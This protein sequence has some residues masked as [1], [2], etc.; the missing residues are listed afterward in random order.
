[1]QLPAKLIQAGSNTLH[2]EIHKR[3]DYILNKEELPQQWKE[4]IIILIYKRGEKTAII[5]D[6]YHC[7]KLHTK[8]YPI[9]FSQS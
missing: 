8:F 5:I 1:M 9:F 6:G 4:S 3:I 2:S 7:Y